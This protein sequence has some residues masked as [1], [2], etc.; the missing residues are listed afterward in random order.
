MILNRNYLVLCVVVLCIMF[1]SFKHGYHETTIIGT[2]YD[3][4][5]NEPL[6]EFEFVIITDHADLGMPE[7]DNGIT[8]VTTDKDGKFSLSK[9]LRNEMNSFDFSF[10]KR[11]SIQFINPDSSTICNVGKVYAVRY[12]NELEHAS[13]ESQ[14]R[15]NTSGIEQEGPAI[16]DVLEFI[17]KHAPFMVA[18][19]V[20]IKTVEPVQ[21]PIPMPCEYSSKMLGF[22][23]DLSR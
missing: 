21:E 13:S 22:K 16:Q 5:T 15:C 2:I 17:S 12:D 10:S 4:V 19:E 14:E 1:F 20:E 9:Q 23:V 6:S 8:L 3:N 18:N 11:A 7:L